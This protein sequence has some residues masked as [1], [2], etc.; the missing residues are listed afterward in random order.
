[1][2]QFSAI[3]SA[4]KVEEHIHAASVIR[5]VVT[6]EEAERMF[7]SITYSKGIRQFEFTVG[8]PLLIRNDLLRLGSGLLIMLRNFV[9]H[10]NFRNAI[11]AF[12]E[13]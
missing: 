3:R 11:V 8:I 9:G 5:E 6:V 1:M 2:A 10:D 12:M 4:M 7:D 13:R